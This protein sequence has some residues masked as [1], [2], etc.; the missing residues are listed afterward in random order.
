MTFNL[1]YGNVK[2]PHS[3]GQRR[4]VTKKLIEV[5]SPDII[6]TQEGF[7]WQ[8]KDMATDLP[9]YSWIGL[10]REG[11]SRSEY[12]AIFYR[13]A[14][15]E[16]LEYDHFWLSDTPEVM[17]SS[18]WGNSNRRM[19]TWVKFRDR[20][21]G[22]EFYHWNTHFDHE[23][24]LA[25]QKSAALV[26]A[27]M[28]ALKTTLPIVLTGDF[29][30]DDKASK[31]YDILTG[32]GEGEGALTDLWFSAERRFG[33]SY[34]SFHGYEKPVKDGHH[35]DWILSRGAVTARE[36]QLVDF[37]LEGQYPSDHFPIMVAVDIK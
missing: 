15:L 30:A 18:T 12:M 10:G 22:V 14:R 37:S 2:P 4:P 36:A 35:I 9:A 5:A 3:W 7:Y 1:R 28:N 23:I 26:L 6:G 20:Q 31:T 11:G 8:L 32:R 19:V 21:S 27:R 25:R 34:G 17:G 16:P 33:P 13:T 24:E 29:N